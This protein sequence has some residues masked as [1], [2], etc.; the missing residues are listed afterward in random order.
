MILECKVGEDGLHILRRATP[1][2]GHEPGLGPPQTPPNP[3]FP[4]LCYVSQ[5]RRQSASPVHISTLYC[6]PKRRRHPNPTTQNVYPGLTRQFRIGVHYI[7][8]A[9]QP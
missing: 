4:A 2:P 6:Q 1:N 7:F 3:V 8:L 5:L 9:P